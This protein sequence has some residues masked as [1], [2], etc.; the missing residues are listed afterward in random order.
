M[1]PLMANMGASRHFFNGHHIRDAPA[2]EGR[3]R[4]DRELNSKHNTQQQQ[5]YHSKASPFNYGGITVR[6]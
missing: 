3:N 5:T 1:P 2:P 4:A 6:V